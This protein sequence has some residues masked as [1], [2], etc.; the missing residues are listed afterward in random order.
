MP[1]DLPTTNA[2]LELVDKATLDQL[3]CTLVELQPGQVLLQSG[4]PEVHAYFPIN[5]VL[6]LMSTM[7]SGSSSEVALVGREGMVGLFGVLAGSESATSCIVQ[8]GGT[9]LRTS[10]AAV[11][12]GRLRSGALRNAIDRYIT[13]RLIHV[14]QVAA[15]GR[16]HPIGNRLARW[17]LALHDRVDADRFKLSQQHIADSLGVHRP[18][19]AVELQKLDAIG[20]IVYRSRTVGIA[21]RLLLESV[22][23]ECHAALHREY[24]NLFRPIGPPPARESSAAQAN[25]VMG[26][27][28]L[29]SIAGRLLVT[30]LREQQA[31]ERAEA[32]NEEK[33]QFLAM[34]SH[35]LRTPLQAILGWCELS[36]RPGAPPG[37]IEVIERNA[38]AQLAI[39]ND[40]LDSSRMSAK[41]LR[42][43]PAEINPVGVI[44][45]ALDTIRPAAEAKHIELKLNVLDEEASLVAD[46]DRLRQVLVNVLMNSVKFS[47]EGDSV[48]TE[49]SSQGKQ[50][51]LR[52]IDHGRGISPNALPHVFERF[53]QEGAEP[54]RRRGLGLGLS[55]SRALVE[56]HG[57][58]ITIAS[59]GEGQGT[60]C[61]ITLPRPDA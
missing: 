10:A 13:A 20:A 14:A 7:E 61:T 39:I 26:I 12:V 9:C 51:E 27:E 29:R 5:A 56:L 4:A 17:L 1:V 15:C 24:V 55:I 41:T 52:V 18:T 2:L 44:E 43:S 23:C 37:A 59:S 50:V 36:R 46:G 28:V 49:V 48:D 45:S 22:A 16:L 34:I 54:I 30:S 3:A 42:I 31:R 57:G 33:D 11:R 25:G 8:I 40:L 53:W 58:T 47:E 21:N 38:R 60:T 6:S 32:A 35:E 19:I